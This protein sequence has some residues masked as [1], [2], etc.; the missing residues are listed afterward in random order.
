MNDLKKPK[1]GLLPLMLE[2]YKEYSPE[3]AEKQAPF[4]KTVIDN[5]Q[6]FSE[7]NAVPV[8][9][10]T[11][12][13]KSSIKEFERKDVDLIVI[14]FIAYAASIS[15]LRPLLDTKIPLLLFSTSPKG[16]MAEGM[17]SED[18]MLNHGIHGYMDLANVLKRNKRQFIFVSGKKDD[19]KTLNDIEQWSRTAKTV[20]LLKKSTIGIAG[21]TFDGMGDFGVDTTM[22]NAVLGPEV[23]HVPVLQF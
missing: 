13:A 2:L 18:I 3:M 11:N 14:V 15:A 20:S 8:C 7:V 6:T 5:L 16:S 12:M 10:N 17:N 21:Y 22:L 23:K 19:K 1:I 9:S 4:L